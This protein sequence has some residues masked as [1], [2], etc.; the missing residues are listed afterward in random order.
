MDSEDLS[1][2][3]AEAINGVG[4]DQSR[5]ATTPSSPSSGTARWPRSSGSG[6]S[7]RV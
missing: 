7:T 3:Y 2:L 5:F 6:G 4:K 1:S